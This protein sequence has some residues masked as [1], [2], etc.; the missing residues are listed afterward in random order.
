MRIVV[1]GF[2]TVLI[3]CLSP[4]ASRL[5]S[6]GLPGAP[7]GVELTQRLKKHVWDAGEAAKPADAR[8]DTR[9]HSSFCTSHEVTR[10]KAYIRRT[11]CHVS[12]ITRVPAWHMFLCDR[13]TPPDSRFCLGRSR[14]RIIRSEVGRR[15]RDVNQAGGVYWRFRETVAAVGACD[16]VT[17]GL[18]ICQQRSLAEDEM[19]REPEHGVFKNNFSELLR[20]AL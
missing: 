2:P 7:N 20:L 10:A 6:T 13:R 4:P 19:L 9:P 3:S 18:T 11:K 5:T 14:K 15:C 16:G 1:C 8:S 17:S 12:L